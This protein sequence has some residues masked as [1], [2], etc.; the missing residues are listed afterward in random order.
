MNKC[1]TCIH[2]KNS[3]GIVYQANIFIRNKYKREC[4]CKTCILKANC[5]LKCN[6]RENHIEK[7]LDELEELLLNEGKM[8]P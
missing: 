7:M 1:L 6:A 3:C 4:P 5:S 2:E 8:G